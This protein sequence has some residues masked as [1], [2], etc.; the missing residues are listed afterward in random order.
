MLCELA[1][2]SLSYCSKKVEKTVIEFKDN[3]TQP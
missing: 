1:I 2:A 3:K